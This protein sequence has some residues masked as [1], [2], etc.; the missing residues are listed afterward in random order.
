MAS[1]KILVIINISLALLAFLLILQL[2]E[3]KLPVLGKAIENKAGAE[4]LI[5]WDNE[6]TLWNDLDHCCLEAR[7]QLDCRKDNLFFESKNFD[8][9]CQTGS[10]RA[11][12]YW[13]NDRAYNYCTNQVIW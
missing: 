8:W 10:G 12:K 1:N 3:I 7:K 6:Y 9:V 13:L 11:L 4:C 5:D 2:F